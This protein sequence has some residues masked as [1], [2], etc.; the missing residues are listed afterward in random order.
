MTRARPVQDRRLDTGSANRRSL[1]FGMTRKEF[2]EENVFRP[3]DFEEHV[4]YSSGKLQ[5]SPLRFATV[6]MTKGRV[7]LQLTFMAGNQKALFISF[8]GQ[9]A[10]PGEAARKNPR[11]SS[12][13]DT[14]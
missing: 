7:A 4:H 8:G 3:G 1:G 12:G 13:F 10:H 5:I 6:E 11:F 2:G 9:T 14:F